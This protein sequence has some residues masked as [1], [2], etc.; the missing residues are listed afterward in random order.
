MFMRPLNLLG[1]LALSACSANDDVPSPSIAGLQPD[2]G[3]PGI[4]V[5][6]SGSY[7]CQQPR[8]DG[9]DV[10][11]LACTHI[12][13]VSFGTAPGI[14]LSYTDTMATV[15]VPALAS[16][17]FDVGVSVAGRT[18]NRISFLVE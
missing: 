13:T 1:W 11:P 10:D 7:L 8:A 14:V 3:V 5:T 17:T 4:T 12:G 6:V 16:G 15:Q 2:H 9:T 18:S